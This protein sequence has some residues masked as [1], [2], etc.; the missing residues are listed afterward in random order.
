[1]QAQYHRIS[2]HD[3]IV[4]HLRLEGLQL[5]FLFEKQRT[6]DGHVFVSVLDRI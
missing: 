1:M 5:R 4:V 6:Q 3:C 2:S